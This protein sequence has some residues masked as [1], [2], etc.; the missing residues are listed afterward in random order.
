MAFRRSS[1]FNADID[2]NLL[3]WIEAASGQYTGPYD[4]E[5]FS[6]YRP[7]DKRQHGKR[8][9]GAVDLR[10][11]DPKTG[12]ELENYQDPKNFA[13]Y[14]KLANLVRQQQMAQNADYADRLRWGG[15]FGGGAG[16]YGAM[17]LMHFDVG[18]GAGLGMAGGGWDTGLTPQQA[19]AWGLTPGGGVAATAGGGGQM[20]P[21]SVEQQQAAI[22][23]A[24]REMEAGGKYNVIHGGR[25]FEGNVHPNVR[26]PI[27]GPAGDYSTAAGGYQF[28]YPTWQEFAEKAGVK[29]FSPESQ[30]KAAWA[31]A[32]ETL[33]GEKGLAQD[34]AKMAEMLGGR[35]E[36]LKN[37]PAKFASLYNEYLGGKQAA[38]GTNVALT[39]ST[40]A[41]ATPAVDAAKAK[42]PK[43]FSDYIAD[44]A[45]NFGAG[46]TGGGG[47]AALPSSPP[48]TALPS[49]AS[50]PISSINPEA[51]AMQRQQLAQAV[52]RLNSG[53]LY[54]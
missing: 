51:A 8:G 19:A 22:L 20:G 24:I 40:P 42:K 34:P 13:E 17:D 1:Q 21:Y 50:A 37:D 25:T 2:P 4:V 35:W 28:T 26:V 11:I 46:Q 36:A 45:E 9:S 53:K 16:K 52:A 31:L 32:L 10:L 29:D 30:D 39:P 3:K 54:G 6:G 38:P 49:I 33:G 47:G 7:G 44:M 5:V 41:S 12:R 48:V 14:Q 43:S 18:G 27:S 15:Y 23:R